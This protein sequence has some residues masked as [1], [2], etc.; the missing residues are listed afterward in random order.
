MIHYQTS[1]PVE[2]SFKAELA[3]L[4]EIDVLSESNNDAIA[5]ALR[6]A[7]SS[8]EKQTI[9]GVTIDAIED[10]KAK[11]VSIRDTFISK[12]SVQKIIK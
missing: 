3:N 8:L 9:E 5:K 11:S 4:E 2:P 1:H 12:L 7:F 6:L 10:I